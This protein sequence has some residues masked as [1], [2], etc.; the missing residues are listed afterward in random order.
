MPGVESAVMAALQ[1]RAPYTRAQPGDGDQR[2]V[3]TS[4]QWCSSLAA[5]WWRQRLAA[6]RGPTF[7]GERS[8]KRAHLW[9]V[10]AWFH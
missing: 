5:G 3:P 8:A 10:V 2:P 6:W 1:S 9:A 7:S 4:G